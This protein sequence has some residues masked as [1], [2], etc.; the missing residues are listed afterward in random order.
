MQQFKITRSR[1]KGKT[2]KAKGINPKTG[3]EMTIHGGQNGVK[4]GPKNRKSK[5]V[6]SFLA[7]HGDPKTAKQYI[8]RRRWLG[9]AKIGS[10]VNI[11]SN[12]F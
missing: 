5:T 7:R 10:K 1:N 2:W 9:G 11:P 4:V 8:N 6:A 3:R 12:F